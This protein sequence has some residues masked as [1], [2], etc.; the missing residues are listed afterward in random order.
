MGTEMERLNEKYKLDTFSDSKLNS[1]SDED[2]QYQ[3]QHQYEM[4]IKEETFKEPKCQE[5]L[6]MFAI[7]LFLKTTLPIKFLKFWETKTFNL[8]KTLI[9]TLI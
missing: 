7:T 5:R 6:K 1:E 9:L 8:C 4:L 3:Y 2:D